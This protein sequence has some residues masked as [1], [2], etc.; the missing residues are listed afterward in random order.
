M[1]VAGALIM[2][3]DDMG[4]YSFGEKVC[5]FHIVENEIFLCT[6]FKLHRYL[7]AI[8]SEVFSK[9]WYVYE[10]DIV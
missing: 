6:P 1:A 7:L 8:F 4:V 10:P 5:Q 3:C 9:I 2:V